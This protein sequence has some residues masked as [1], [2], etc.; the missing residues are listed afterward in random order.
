MGLMCVVNEL[1]LHQGTVLEVGW[2]IDTTMESLSGRSVTGLTVCSTEHVLTL[3]A[4]NVALITWDLLAS[5]LGLV[6]VII[7]FL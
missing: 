4:W 2:L 1:T 5:L 3:D 7:D 6:V